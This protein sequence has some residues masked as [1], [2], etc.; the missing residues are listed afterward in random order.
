MHLIQVHLQNYNQNDSIET[1]QHS[2][3]NFENKK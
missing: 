1:Y 3:V 2:V